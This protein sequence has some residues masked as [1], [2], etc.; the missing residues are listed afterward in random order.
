VFLTASSPQDLVTPLKPFLEKAGIEIEAGDYILQVIETLQPRCKTLADMAEAALFYYQSDIVYDEKA[1]KKFL[2][3]ASLE[4]LKILADKLEALEDYTQ[5][6]LEDVF[7]TVMDE[8]GLKL[9]KIAQPVRVALTGRTAS[10][11]I[12]EIIAI[13]DKERVIPRLHKAIQFIEARVASNS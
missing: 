7:K 4:P 6:D 13:L 11:G 12:F 1:A 8:T 10:P 9:G 3:A 5:S 2:K